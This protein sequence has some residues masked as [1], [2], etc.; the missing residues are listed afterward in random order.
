MLSDRSYMRDDYPRNSTTVLTWL[1]SAIVAVFVLQHVLWRLFNAEGTL[2]NLLVLTPDNIKA[3]KIWTLFTYSFVHSTSN[4]LHII[5]NLLGLYF[6]G[7]VLE[8]LLGSRRFIW[9]YAALVASGGAA[10]LATHWFG[11]G[12]VIGASA[13]VVGLFIVYACFYPNQPMTF[14]LFFILPITLKPKYVAFAL[15]AIELL[16]FAFYEVLGA[17][18][19]F[20][21]SFA[22][23]AH[24]GGMLAGWIYFRYV[25]SSNWSLAGSAADVELPNWLK[26]KAK[27]AQPATFQVDLTR[28]EDLRAEVDRI[29]DKINSHG[30]GAL[31]AD[32]KRLLDE[33][34][35]LLSRR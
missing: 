23:S 14:L 22:H 2:A 3:G 32:E 13:G 1:I 29:L 26:K 21:S 34:R 9:L 17:A 5:S 25:H 6:I 33:A 8:P 24:L 19:P 18:S 35:D 31:T 11:G 27:T 20:G 10:W 30:F 16:G 15:V 12:A 7:R 4:F 28:R